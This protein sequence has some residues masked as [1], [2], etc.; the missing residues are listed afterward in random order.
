MNNSLPKVANELTLTLPSWTFGWNILNQTANRALSEPEQF[1]S[2]SALKMINERR[3]PSVDSA[4]DYPTIKRNKTMKFVV[5]AARSTTSARRLH[6]FTD[7]TRW[8]RLSRAS[9][10]QRFHLVQWSQKTDK[11]TRLLIFTT[12]LVDK[13]RKTIRRAQPVTTIN[14]F[15]CFDN[16]NRSCR[17]SEAR[18]ESR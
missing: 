7:T 3:T 17:T 5:L 8:S 14:S 1:T 10:S 12:R 9:P 4:V 15:E 18:H 13:S 16:I 11:Q 6:T 2:I